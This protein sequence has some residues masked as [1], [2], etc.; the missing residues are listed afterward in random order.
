MALPNGPDQA[1]RAFVPRNIHSQVRALIETVSDYK[2]QV[3]ID[4][5]QTKSDNIDYVEGESF[6]SG[7]DLAMS[8]YRQKEADNPKHPVICPPLTKIG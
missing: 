4:V 6:C 8:K 3:F 1:K 7:T 2:L 5:F